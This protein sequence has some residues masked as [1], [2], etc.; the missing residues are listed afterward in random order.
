MICSPG[1]LLETKSPR[2]KER[3]NLIIRQSGTRIKNKNEKVLIMEIKPSKH[4]PKSKRGS[5]HNYDITG[6]QA[7]KQ[8]YCT[9][10]N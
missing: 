3:K 8:A 1:Q 4:A 10:Q 2:M 9:N 5:S 7:I 6:L